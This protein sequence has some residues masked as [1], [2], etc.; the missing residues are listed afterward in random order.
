VVLLM[1]VGPRGAAS[2]PGPLSSA[3]VG[4]GMSRTREIAAKS[5]VC[6]AKTRELGP[7]TRAPAP[8][9]GAHGPRSRG[10]GADVRAFTARPRVSAWQTRACA[11][12]A[13]AQ[14]SADGGSYKH[15]HES[16]PGRPGGPCALRRR[17][18]GAIVLGMGEGRRGGG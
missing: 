5:R 13:Q 6:A 8:R 9:T 17:R 4:G 1:R 7:C 10:R 11:A 18:A 16:P 3:L 14:A 15:G 2:H 12:S